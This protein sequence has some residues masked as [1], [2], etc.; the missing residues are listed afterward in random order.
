MTRGRRLVTDHAIGTNEIAGNIVSERLVEEHVRQARYAALRTDVS[1][2][3]ARGDRP[4]VMLH[5][6]A[7][8]L[9]DHLNVAFARI[10]TLR[11][12]SSVLELQA[13]AGDYTRLDGWYARVPLGELKIGRI[14]L[15]RAPYLTN[16]VL[17]DPLIEDKAWAKREG[18]IAFAG[19]PLVAEDHVVGVMAMFARCALEP[20]TLEALSSISTA[21]A[22]R[23][24]RQRSEDEL[25]RS[26]AYLNEGQ[27]LTHT[28]SWA[29]DLRTGERFW[30][31][32]MFRIFGFEP[33]D[34]PPPL[35]A[36]EAR[37][38]PDQE[39]E[40]RRVFEEAYRTGTEVRL[41][42]RL[43]I[44]DP[45]VTKWVD[46][47]GHPVRDEDGQLLEFIGTVV[48]VTDRVRADR[49]LRR[50]IKARY[51]A[52]LAERTRIARDMHDG[53]LQDITGIALQLGA[54]LPHVRTAPDVAADRLKH[55]LEWVVRTSREARE[56]VVGMR[57]G[58]ASA[59]LVS[60]VQSAAQRVTAQ[61]A[62]ALTIRVTGRARPVPMLVRDVAVSIVHETM[63]NVLK[64]ADAGAVEVAV[65][66]GRKRLRLSVCD[67]GRGLTV[68][69]DGA[70]GCK[71]FG[72]AGIRER[73]AVVGAS[74]AVR[75][76]PGKGVTVQLEVP[77]ER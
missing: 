50:A 55:I 25:R 75:S 12:G 26:E 4:R 60:A 7:Q 63:M 17:A 35:E 65:T 32:E 56:T 19:Y 70:E 22:Q 1:V 27:R 48:D 5:T 15:E 76:A 71:H 64:H 21:L 51:E 9:V 30:S 38:D 16:D 44:G 74:L 2:A 49:R 53:L 54:V 37:V 8:A 45:P 62:L 40:V 20:E 69:D 28:G 33:A 14:A 13:S 61:S 24:E 58:E 72:L 66:F 68:P 29:R 57:V 41:H 77:Y 34:I 18:M 52:V 36:A 23:I 43:V 10:W 39:P 6:C 11:C 46:M 31:R 42:M 67:D 59:D 3:L 73:A 47:H